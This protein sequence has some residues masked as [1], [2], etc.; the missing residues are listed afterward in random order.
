MIAYKVVTNCGR[1]VYNY[2]EE[3]YTK[4][5]KVGGITKSTKGRLG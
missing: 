1:S 3:K 4:R 5:Y 2:D